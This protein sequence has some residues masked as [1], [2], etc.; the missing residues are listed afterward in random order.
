MNVSRLLDFDFEL[1]AN[2]VAIIKQCQGCYSAPF[3][4][5]WTRSALNTRLL[6][7]LNATC[8]LFFV[9]GS[10]FSSVLPGSLR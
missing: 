3:W 2:T 6:N 5:K 8:S 7:Q 9:S 1:F 4:P 10:D